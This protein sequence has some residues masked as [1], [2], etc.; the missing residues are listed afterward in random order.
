M[1]GFQP[2]VRAGSKSPGGMV[3]HGSDVQLPAEPDVPLVP[4][5]APPVPPAAPPVAPDPPL[6]LD[7]PPFAPPE[8]SPDAPLAPEPLA[9]LVPSSSFEPV[10]PTAAPTHR[11]TT[12]SLTMRAP[13]PPSV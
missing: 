10:Q 11:T 2:V 3:L 12:S 9:P 6:P 7:E 8:P 1:P 13:R 4:P 5:L